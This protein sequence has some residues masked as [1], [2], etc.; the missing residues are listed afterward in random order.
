ML[1]T[2]LVVWNK[3]IVLTKKLN[4]SLSSIPSSEVKFRTITIT[5]AIL[6][7][8]KWKKYFQKLL[9]DVV[10]RM[11]C[12]WNVL[13]YIHGT[14]DEFEVQ[15]LSNTIPTKVSHTQYS[16]CDP[17]FTIFLLRLFLLQL[18]YSSYL[19]YCPDSSCRSL[20]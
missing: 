1:L 7:T 20:H 9:K 16:V 18:Q 4:T 15:F 12:W 8:W 6:F 2:C 17:L 19:I 10:T 14:V 3:E 13:N 11:Q 5:I